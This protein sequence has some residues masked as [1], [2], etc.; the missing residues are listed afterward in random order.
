MTL[1][2]EILFEKECT[3]KMLACLCLSGLAMALLRSNGI[4][5]IVPT[6]LAGG[7]YLKGVGRKRIFTALAVVFVLYEVIVR[8]IY[9]AMGI[10]KASIS[11]T[12]GFMFQATARYVQEYPEE[13]TEYER[14]VLVRNFQSMD[15]FSGYDPRIMDPVKIYYN[16]SDFDSYL[17]IWWEM[18]LKHPMTYVES[19]LNG[20]YGYMAPVSVD[21]GAYIMLGEYDPYLREF[22][23]SHVENGHL[24]YIAVWLWN[25]NN[26]LP[27]LRY[28]ASPGLYTWLTIATCWLLW[29]NKKTGG[30]ILLIPSLVN[31]LVCTAS[32]L[33]DAMRY[34]LPAVAMMPF[35]IGWLYLLGGNE[36][37]SE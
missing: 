32:P 14:E 9:P 26:G 7:I 30:V 36:G 29:K 24:N 10:G 33:A 2:A 25:L 27:L 6:L 5:A 8:G 1:V 31:I 15:V 21:I 16:H 11:E 13:I 12:I 37:F 4:Y 19:Y 34:A 18:F 22:G 23:L 35:V 17:E 3:G 20:S 28:L